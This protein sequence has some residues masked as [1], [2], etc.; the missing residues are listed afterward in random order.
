MKYLNATI[1]LFAL[2]LFSHFLFALDQDTIQKNVSDMYLINP[3]DGSEKI[4]NF[5][6]I[7]YQ[8]EKYWLLETNDKDLFV[9]E[10]KNYLQLVT[11]EEIKPV[12]ETYFFFS[13]STQ[14]YDN[15]KI[16][17]FFNTLPNAIT[18]FNYNLE[19]V[20]K[21]IENLDASQE[22][23]LLGIQNV[24][25]TTKEIGELSIDITNNTILLDRNLQT[26]AYE[27]YIS[28]KTSTDNLQT[29]TNNFLNKLS[30]LQGLIMNVKIILV[31][32]N[33]PLDMKTSIGNNLLVLPQEF[34]NVPEYISNLSTNLNTL[35]SAKEYSEN[36]TNIEPLL[37]SWD[38]RLKRMSFLELYLGY[39][40]ELEKTTKQ[41]NPKSFFDLIINSKDTWKDYN[42]TVAFNDAYTMMYS[43]LGKKEY[44]SAKRQIKPLKDMA[45]IIYKDGK[46]DIVTSTN[47]NNSTDSSS[48]DQQTN[49]VMLVAIIVVAGIILV[50]IITTIIKKIKEAKEKKEKENDPEVD[51]KF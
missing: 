33:I 24:Q 48:T 39:D 10:D 13:K 34:Q 40:K 41:T 45:L 18:N 1:F 43:D 9:V 47:S 29:D 14:K 6:P 2:I 21:E 50:I 17:Y 16:A 20:K 7:I 28:I 31:D 27:N 51:V 19:L 3:L 15:Q 12:A 46:K 23:V 25:L 36:Y 26:Q 35:N 32:A 5:Y 4:D 11:T 8:K 44:D 38:A 49:P 30:K 42:K 37:T 22:N